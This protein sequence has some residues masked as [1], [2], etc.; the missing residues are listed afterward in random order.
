MANW[1]PITLGDL[2]DARMAP[3]VDAAR[4]QALTDD[5]PDPV[6]NLIQSVVDRIRWKIASCKLNSIDVDTTK[7]PKGLRS[8]AVDLIIEKLKRR[9]EMD[10][11]EDERDQI[12]RHEAD[13]NQIAQCK[14]S[15]DP[16]DDPIAT[17]GKDSGGN[18]GSEKQIPMR[19]HD[20][21]SGTP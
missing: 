13:L 12:K 6:P 5:Q 14:L 21:F 10:L 19:T 11:R 8:M 17:T 18:W 15:V 4:S 9:L 3:L 2:E 7:I 16:P 20:E 1:I